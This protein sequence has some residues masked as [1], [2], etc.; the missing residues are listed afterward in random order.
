MSRQ[1]KMD[2]TA[3]L[4]GMPQMAENKRQKGRRDI[5]TEDVTLTMSRMSQI[6]RA[7]LAALV[8]LDGDPALRQ[9]LLG[10]SRA[11][12]ETSLRPKRVLPKQWNIVWVIDR[13]TD[14]MRV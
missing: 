8:E 9:H 2:A 4:P 12:V 1:Q 6:E 13:L 3:P 7:R 11:R 5:P 10:A 14:A